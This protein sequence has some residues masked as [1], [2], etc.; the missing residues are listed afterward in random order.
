MG[1]YSSLL[2]PMWDMTGNT[3]YVRAYLEPQEAATGTPSGVCTTSKQPVSYD[4]WYS[5]WAL[6]QE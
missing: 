6:L 3:T 2:R 1:S 4:P 5:A